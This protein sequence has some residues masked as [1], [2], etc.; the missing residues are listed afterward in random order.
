MVSLNTWHTFYLVLP[1]YYLFESNKLSLIKYFAFLR[2]E[3]RESSRL[4]IGI[5]WNFGSVLFLEI[6]I[7]FRAH[8]NWGFGIMLP[9][10]KLF[11]VLRSC[12]L[13]LGA[14]KFGSRNIMSA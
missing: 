12:L 13:L 14:R 6:G 8:R 10:A 9:N 4:K 11:R 3:Y 1:V 7:G 2:L 5:N